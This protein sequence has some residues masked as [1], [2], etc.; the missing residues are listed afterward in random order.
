[1]FANQIRLLERSIKL[2]GDGNGFKLDFWNVGVIKKRNLCTSAPQ[3]FELNFLKNEKFFLHENWGTTGFRCALYRLA[4]EFFKNSFRNSN[5]GFRFN[6]QTILR[7]GNVR[8]RFPRIE[9]PFFMTINSYFPNDPDLFS[10]LIWSKFV[11]VRL[12]DPTLM[13]IRSR[14]LNYVCSLSLLANVI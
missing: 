12:T 5:S 9:K 10:R 3:I 2:S 11:P 7:F 8:N 13:R 4:V 14:S 6:T 1:M